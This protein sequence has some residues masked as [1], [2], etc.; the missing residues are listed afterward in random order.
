[1]IFRNPPIKA[2]DLAAGY[3][4]RPV[5]SELSLEVPP[6]AVCALLGRNGAGK[7]TLLRVLLGFLEPKSG[8][9]EVLGT[10]AWHSRFALRD[11]IGFVAER[12]DFWPQM[13][14]SE[15]LR[16]ASKLHATWDHSLVERLAG[17]CGLPLEERLR[18]YSKGMQVLL[19][20][21]LALGHRPELLILDEPAAGLDPVMRSEFA[22]NLLDYVGETGATAIYST[23]LVDEVQGLADE[24][25]VLFGGSILVSGP[26]DEIIGRYG[27]VTV[28]GDGAVL[29]Q[30]SGLQ[31]IA[32]HRRAD[33][34]IVTV[35]GDPQAA[36][37]VLRSVGLSVLEARR[38]TLQELYIAFLGQD[39]AQRTG[40]IVHERRELGGAA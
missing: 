23:H 20:Q 13:R 10:D 11:R 19:A 22:E 4:R 37:A 35:V 40:S 27:R 32:S 38:P 1:M 6:G 16:L 5:L 34:A 2:E 18:T 8:H 24:V 31:V 21:V 3:G 29:A 26:L 30:I 14:G 12:Q 9:V 39:N 28:M 17:R 36:A 25:A 33:A 15:L 7:T